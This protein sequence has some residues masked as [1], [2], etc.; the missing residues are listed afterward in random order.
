MSTG[1]RSVS[2]PGKSVRVLARFGIAVAAAAVLFPTHAAFAATVVLDD[3]DSVD[4]S[5][6]AEPGEANRLVVQADAAGVR[7]IDTGAVLLTRTCRSVSEHE[8]FCPALVETLIV[9]TGDGDDTIDLSAAPIGLAVGG[10]GNDLIIAASSSGDAGDDELRGLSVA[11]GQLRGGPGNDTIRAGSRGDRLFGGAGNDTLI[12]GVGPDSMFGGDGPC[13]DCPPEVTDDDTLRGGAGNDTLWIE[14]GRD[15]LDGQ[16]G[17]DAYILDLGAQRIDATI[18]DSG[19]DS[20]DTIAMTACAGV[21]VSTSGGARERRGRY[22]LPSGAVVFAGIDGTL[23][24]ATKPVPRVVGMSLSRARKALGAS[25]FRVGKIT[26][27]R[28][29]AVRRGTVTR[30]RPAAGKRLPAGSIVSLI[31]SSGPR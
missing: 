31:V 25:G 27:A 1:S 21:R 9:E 24:C 3:V 17:D 4:I 16:A 29:S 11:A 18:V 8:V 6:L 20:H 22:A 28:S 30:Q 10:A 14:E 23:P 13:D 5:F 19:G 15:H 12:G 2:H 7:F 26:Y